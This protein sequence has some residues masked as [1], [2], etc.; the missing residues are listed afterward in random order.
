MLYLN[1]WSEPCFC[2]KQ[3]KGDR[4]GPSCKD[5]VLKE[6]TCGSSTRTQLVQKQPEPDSIV[7]AVSPFPLLLLL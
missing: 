5:G 4:D 3:K 2:F 6:G 1:L 7:T